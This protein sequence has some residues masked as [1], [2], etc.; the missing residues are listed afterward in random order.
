[1]AYNKINSINYNLNKL[2]KEEMDCEI[3]KIIN[4]T[5]QLENLVERTSDQTLKEIN[6]LDRVIQNYS[7]RRTVDKVDKEEEDETNDNTHPH[8][9]AWSLRFFKFCTKKKDDKKYLLRAEIP[10]SDYSAINSSLFAHNSS[11][12]SLSNDHP[13]GGFTN[14]NYSLSPLQIFNSALNSSP[15]IGHIRER[16]ESIISDDFLYMKRMNALKYR[17]M[18]QSLYNGQIQDSDNLNI[19][20]PL[21]LKFNGDSNMEKN[22]I[23]QVSWWHTMIHSIRNVFK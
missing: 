5:R 7:Q 11:D 9:H 23:G 16:G 18:D 10:G 20:T 8:P 4:E 15:T 19:V 1:M 14:H 2:S 21:L 3:E 12:L 13:N 17:L 6:R 22:T